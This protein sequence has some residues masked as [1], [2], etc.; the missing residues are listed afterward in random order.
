VAEVV[1]VVQ[2]AVGQELLVRLEQ[3]MEQRI[4]VAVVEVLQVVLISPKQALVVQA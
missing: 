2:V 1:L 4:L 3:E